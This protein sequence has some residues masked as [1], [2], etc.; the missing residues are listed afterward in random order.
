RVNI[1]NPNL[2]DTMLEL[3][4]RYELQPALLNL[5]LTESAYTDN[6]ISMKKMITKLQNHGF[7]I[8]MDDFGSGYS[9]LALL[10]DIALDVLKIDMLFL[11][12]T[13]IPGRGENIIASVIRM[14]KWLNIPVIA[15]GAETSE[16]VDFLR[17]VGCDYVQGYYFARPMPTTE[18][19]QLYSSLGYTAQ[20]A[21]NLDAYHYDDL[22][23][24]TPEMKL[25]FSSTLQVAVI[26]EFADEQ[27]EM[28]R[29][30]E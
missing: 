12:K 23:S 3:L 5:E 11:S 29:V 19:E 27:I 9:S 7:T 18:Y 14:A 13:E 15:E 1:Y 22:F 17:S 4:E 25:L 10:K 6:P 2:L 26:Y 24:D 30:N 8:L 21:S 28:I 20:A 16:Q